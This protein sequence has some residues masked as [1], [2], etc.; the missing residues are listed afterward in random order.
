MSDHP[1]ALL[2][3][4]ALKPIFRKLKSAPLVR[5]T[6]IE[7]LVARWEFADQRFAAAIL[8]GVDRSAALRALGVRLCL[9][10][11]YQDSQA[12]LNAALGCSPDHVGIINDLAVV[13]DRSGLTDRAAR[14]V[15]RSLALQHNQPDSWIF[16]GNLKHQLRDLPAAA[17]AFE[18]AISLAANA[19]LAWQGLGLV[20]Q[21]Q[22]Q[23][24]PAIDCF[25]TCLRLNFMTPPILAILG[26]LFYSTGQFH[27]SRDAFAASLDRDSSN[28]V[29]RRMLGEMRFVTAI[30]DGQT[31]ESALRDRD[32]CSDSEPAETEQLLHKSFAMLSSFGHTT[33]ARTVAQKRHALYPASASAAY[34]VA[35]INGDPATPRSPD[36]YLIESFDSLADRF[37]D[38]LTRELGYEIPQKLSAALIDQVRPDAKLDILDAGCGT[39]LCG[40][41]VRGIAR[42]LSGVDLSPR[43]LEQARRQPYDR[44]VCGELT[45]FLNDSPAQFD[46]VIAADV[47]IYFGDIQPLAAAIARALR[48]GGWV[49]FSIECNGQGDYQLLA[50]GRFSQSSAYIRDTFSGDFVERFCQAVTI[51]TEASRAV[52]GEMFVFQRRSLVNGI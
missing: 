16:L 21:E 14:Q 33:A 12:V 36:Q 38:H 9:S 28:A 11:R 1:A 10:N 32:E 15:E 2:R 41:W 26:Q 6:P 23:F 52:A 35:A 44:L 3:R 24:Q 50:S 40:P 39:G 31:I 34:F 47:L 29:C 17:T 27:R 22:R 30:L 49:A 42:S 43:M 5:S 48:P 18:T 8:A 46:A 4:P 45:A 20:R 7:R 19:P 51:R 13:L 37:D 25:L